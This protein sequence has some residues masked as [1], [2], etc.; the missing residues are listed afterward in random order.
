MNEKQLSEFLENEL[1]KTKSI[2]LGSSSNFEI[3]PDQKEGEFKSF[4]SPEMEKA[5][6]KKP[7]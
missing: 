6:P 7:V 2:S 5:I 4:L 1:G 3:T